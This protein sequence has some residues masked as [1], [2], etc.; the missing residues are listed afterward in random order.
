MRFSAVFYD[1][2]QS[3]SQNVD[4]IVAKDGQVTLN[5]LAEIRA[6]K[7][8]DI[9]VSSQLGSTARSLYFPDGS[10]CETDA[11]EQ[12]NVLLANS[13]RNKAARLLHLLESRL[14]YVLTAAVIVVAFTWFMIVLGLPAL[15]SKVAY[16][17][18]SSVDE[19]LGQGSMELLDK[20]Y[21]DPTELSD[22]VQ[23]RLQIEFQKMVQS[24]RDEHNYEL[25]F[26]S[27]EIIGPNAFALPSGTIVMTDQLV[28][29]AENDEELIA[30]FA[31]EI[32]H[33]VHRHAMRSVLQNSA[34]VLILIAVTG[35]IFASSTFTAALPLLLIQTKFSREFEIEADQFSYEYLIDNNID[36]KHFADIMKRITQDDNPETEEKF[37]YLSTHPLTTE[38][39]RKF[40][41][42]SQSE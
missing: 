36:L 15:A 8:Q 39:I 18:P 29:L 42:N 9:K 31:H 16:S 12:I 26:R 37:K 21:M 13:K 19:T 27:S 20:I 34:V 32:G 17:L 2:K 40:T 25:L 35:D 3:N 23:T 7:W 11:H 28:K 4:V 1:G 38:R 24:I 5:G 10:K 33:V 14:K 41:K 22:E 6:F 30:I